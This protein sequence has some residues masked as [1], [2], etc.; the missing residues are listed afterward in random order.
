MGWRDNLSLFRLLKESEEKEKA[1]K[2]NKIAFVMT[3]S[4]L[5]ANHQPCVISFNYLA[6]T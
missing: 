6:T 3:T 5:N 4:L 1:D 2:K